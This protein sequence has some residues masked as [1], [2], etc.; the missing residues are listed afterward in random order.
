MVA[1]NTTDRKEVRFK[2]IYQILITMLVVALVP[3]GGLWYISIHKSKQEWTTNIFQNLVNNTEHL[4]RSVDEWT[5]TNLRLL[6]QNSATPA[7]LGMQAAAQ[8]PVLKSITDVYQ[9]IYLAFT[10]L[11]DGQNLGRSD[12]KALTYY[13][14]REY[15]KQV[16]GGKAFG[17]QVLLGKTNNKPAFIL[18]KPIKG[19]AGKP[20]G[21]I[22]IAMTLEDLSKSITKTRIGE[23]GFALLLDEQNR[24]IA[25]GRGE[26]AS[27]LQDFSAHPALKQGGKSGRD[28]FV[29]VEAGKKIVAFSQKTNLGWTLIVQQDY[30]EAYAAADEAQRNATLL[31]IATL[32]AVV[33]IAYLL[34][35][36]LSAPIRNLTAIADEISRGNLG[37][38][39][40]ECG[41]SDEIGA[42]ARAIE[43]MGVSLQMAF[44]RLRKR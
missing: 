2:L 44:E 1:D 21:V 16:L 13:G 34:A 43:R 26:V 31:L 9:W 4:T 33:A 39:I 25:H 10:V 15:V 5:A 36:R 37:A 6:E 11:P 29:Y 8:N 41:R 27:E 22:A 20:A 30:R 3:L 40:K 19:D 18:A 24:L 38:E 14:D 32:I 17:Q 28:S 35:R 42:L 12:G 23:T 7:I